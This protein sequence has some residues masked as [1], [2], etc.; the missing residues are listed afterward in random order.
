VD[1][2]PSGD[3]VTPITSARR[4]PRSTRV[5]RERV[6]DVPIKTVPLLP[7]SVGRSARPNRY[8]YLAPL[9]IE[10]AALCEG[11]PQRERL[12]AALITGH[13]PVARNIARKYRYRGENPEDLLQVASVALVLAVDRFDPG[14]DNDFLSFAIPTIT[15]E[16][17]RYLRDN[18][19]AIRV[20]RRLRELQLQIYDAAGELSQR[21]GH[22]PRPSEIARQ[23]NLDVEVV[24][25]GLALGRRLHP[26]LGR[27]GAG[28][29]RR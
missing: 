23:L 7:G 16:V 12:R 4:L 1:F 21:T 15:G 29:R 24:L 22:T 19:T 10:H 8:E 25:E 13:L 26:L 28:R 6:S 11:H 5:I 9:F 3:D 17:L 14:R 27:G 18:A 20:P 2:S